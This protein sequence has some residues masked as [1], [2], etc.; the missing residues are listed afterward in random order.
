ML[1]PGFYAYGRGIQ[2]PRYVLVVLPIASVISLYTI[3]K[4]LSKT[5]L[6]KFILIL[7]LVFIVSSSLAY[8][9][10]KKTDYSHEREAVQLSLIIQT[11]KGGI[12]EFSPE[13][14]YVHTA[15]FHDV[16]MPLLTSAIDFE[17]KIIALDGQTVEEGIMNGRK[18]GLS[19]LIVDNLNT[20]QNRKPFLNDVFYQEE[21]YPYLIK[22]F[23]SKEH[24]YNY[25][26]KIFKI[27]YDKFDSIIQR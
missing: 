21:N 3:E 2:E 13:S 9:E 18:D 7:M 15:T 24:G 25:Q 8:L 12:N 10:F 27:D 11:L 22:I 14:T 26:V 17:P 4:F 16:K 6:T 1:I 5:S 20:K 19:Y 23:D